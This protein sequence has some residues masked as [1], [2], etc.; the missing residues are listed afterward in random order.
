MAKEVKKNDEVVK[1]V[2]EVIEKKDSNYYYTLPSILF[3]EWIAINKWYR[4]DSLWV[5]N[6]GEA[7]SEGIS[8]LELFSLYNST[9]IES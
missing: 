7:I 3:A 9:K 6:Y 5:L 1:E 2:S 8:T 4:A